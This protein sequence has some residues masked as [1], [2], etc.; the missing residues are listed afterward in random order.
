MRAAFEKIALRGFTIDLEVERTADIQLRADADSLTNALWNLLDNAVKHSPDQR[1]SCL[2]SS[3]F[4]RRR[5]F[6]DR[7]WPDGRTNERQSSVDSFV[8]EGEPSR[9]QG[10]WALASPWSRN[11]RGTRR[12]IELESEEGVGSTFRLVLPASE[13]SAPALTERHA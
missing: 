3:S 8:V 2:G 4:R 6:G 5:D 7:R 10:A 13:S 9:H 11:C 12:Q 1:R